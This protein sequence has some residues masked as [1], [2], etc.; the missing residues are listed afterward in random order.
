MDMGIAQNVMC[1]LDKA[2]FATSDWCNVRPRSFDLAT[3]KEDL[4]ILMKV[5]FNIDHL[6]RGTADEMRYL[7][8]RLVGAPLMVGEMARNIPLESGVVYHRHNVPAVN[9]ETLHDYLVEGVPPMIYAAPGGFYVNISGD[10]LR[11]ARTDVGMSIGDLASRI[12]AS[13]RSIRKYEQE[14]MDASIDT[15][16]Q[17]E[18]VLQRLLVSPIDLLS[19]PTDMESTSEEAD[20]S[21]MPMLDKDVIEQLSMMGFDVLTTKRSPFRAVSSDKGGNILTGI[22]RYTKVMIKRARIVSSI[23]NIIRTDAV[24]VVDKSARKTSIGSTVLIKH[25]EFDR[26]GGA[27][28]LIELIRDRRPVRREDENQ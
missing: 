15:A 9:V 26:V 25:D 4:L 27:D 1:V 17:L 12:G 10:V 22:S 7:A 13:R 23:S 2:G 24:F 19:I 11:D 5:L 21:S 3:R 18:E 6:T 28:E 14:G 8:R 20:I 16:M